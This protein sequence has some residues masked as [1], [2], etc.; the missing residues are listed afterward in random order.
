VTDVQSQTTLEKPPLRYTLSYGMR[1]DKVRTHE[2][3]YPQASAVLPDGSAGRM[4][5][6]VTNGTA[7]EIKAQLLESVD[8]FFQ[9]NTGE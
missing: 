2:L 5:L 4:T 9:K 3:A 8:A 1:L 6:Q 7:E